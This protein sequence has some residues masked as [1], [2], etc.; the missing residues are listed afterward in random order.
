M[1]LIMLPDE[2]GGCEYK[3]LA[4]A[5]EDLEVLNK[6]VERKKEKLKGKAGG[7]YL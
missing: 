7:Q 3:N 4:A 2:E 1:W 5:K 6:I